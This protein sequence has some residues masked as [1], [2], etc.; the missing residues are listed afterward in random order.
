[1]QFKDAAYEILKSSGVPLHYNVITDKAVKAGLLE[2]T[3]QTPHATMGALLYTDTLNANSRFRRGDQKGTFALKATAPTGI[4]QQIEAIQ[5]KVRQDLRKH[6]LNM[7]PQKFEELIRSLLEEM[8]F[9]ETETTQYVNDKGVDVRGILKTNQ[10]TTMKVVIQAKRWTNNVGSVPVRNLRGSLRMVDGEQGIIVTPSDFTLDAKAEA[11]SEGKMPITLINGNQ[12]IE[13]LFQYK[14][15]VKQEERIIHSIDTE[16]WTEVLGISLEESE[17]TEIKK[18]GKSK[19]KFPL[20]IEAHYKGKSFTGELL[21]TQGS[22]RWNGQDY[23][24]P[25]TAAKA[26]ATD[27]KQVNGWKFWKYENPEC[28]VW[29]YISNLRED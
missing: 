25:S 7:P 19:I 20:A 12:L 26:I 10:L 17:T 5:K 29:E 6:L 21:D 11:Q 1:M 27:W 22:V 16:Y 24:T 15:G 2:T 13:L 3:G 4:E 14:V 18:I 23:I 8:G 28:E 9:E